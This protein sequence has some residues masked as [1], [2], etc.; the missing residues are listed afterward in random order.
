MSVVC[1]WTFCEYCRSKKLDR[2]GLIK[3]YECV[4]TLSGLSLRERVSRR[5]AAWAR[6]SHC[7]V[8]AFVEEAQNRCANRSAVPST[9]AAEVLLRLHSPLQ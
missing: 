1:D 3:G 9:N 7:T 4:V 5:V 8:K 2:T 6:R